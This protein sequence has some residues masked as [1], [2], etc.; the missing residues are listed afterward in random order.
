MG[1]VRFIH[2]A[3]VHLGAPYG[4]LEPE[5]GIRRREDQRRALGS[6]V[7]WASAENPRVNLMLIAGDL[8]DR[9][10]PSRR[11]VQFVRDVLG[12]A[13]AAGIEVFIVPGNH[14]EY[15]PRCFWDALETTRVHVFR[16]YGFS[17][18]NLEEFD[19]TVWGGV[20]NP[21][22]QGE[23]LVREF[24]GG[25]CAGRSILVLHGTYLN[26]GPDDEP[27]C[28]PFDDDDVRRLNVNYLAFG[29]YH[30]CLE[31]LS[32]R[33]RKGFY[34]GSLVAR[35]FGSTELGERHIIDGQIGEDGE[36]SVRRLPLR[37]LP[38]FPRAVHSVEEFDATHATPDGFRRWLQERASAEVLMRAVVRGTCSAEFAADLEDVEEEFAEQYY[39]LEVRP[40]FELVEEHEGDNPHFRQFREEVLRRMKSA[41]E[42]EQAVLRRCLQVG[43][44]AF[45]KGRE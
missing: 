39:S 35:T 15:R 6:V 14:D 43:A 1:R 10:E 27:R 2:L 16:Q 12:R 45:Y 23:R 17:A 37:S 32:E 38:N 30:G 40:E 44:V 33:S 28:L 25:Q 26:Y 4:F 22:R 20:M 11:E 18:V 13:A 36:V 8:F 34:P 24:D 21:D 31:V 42:E 5:I 29:H 3:D 41:S 19:L 7:A 9:S